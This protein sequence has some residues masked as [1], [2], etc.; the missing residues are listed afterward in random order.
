M[1]HSFQANGK[2]SSPSPPLATLLGRAILLGAK[3]TRRDNFRAWFM[4]VA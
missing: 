2:D 1:L 4:T 3:V